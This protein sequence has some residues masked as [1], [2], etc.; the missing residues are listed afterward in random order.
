MPTIQVDTT[1][2][3]QLDTLVKRNM[4]PGERNKT[5]N[6]VLREIFVWYDVMGTFQKKPPTPF[7]W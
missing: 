6:R 2:K 7:N 3:K 5:Y 1:L 4:L